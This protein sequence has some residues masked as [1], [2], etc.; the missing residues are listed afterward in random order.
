M[1]LKA[2]EVNMADILIIKISG[3]IGSGKSTLA[4]KLENEIKEAVKKDLDE[5]D[6]QYTCKTEIF[7]SA[8]DYFSPVAMRYMLKDTDFDVIT[9][10]RPL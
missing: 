10:R 1:S 2:S 5:R 4:D 6:Q 9:G 8:T 3:G 7:N